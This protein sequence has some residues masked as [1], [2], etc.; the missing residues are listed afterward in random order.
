MWSFLHSKTSL[1]NK[2]FVIRK[3]C[4]EVTALHS[5]KRHNEV[6]AKNV[7]FI[8]T[9]GQKLVKGSDQFTIRKLQK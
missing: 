9:L 1:K 2:H 4:K 5:E 6:A 8:I 3:L 7:I